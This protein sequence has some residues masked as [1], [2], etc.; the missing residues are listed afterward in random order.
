[1]MGKDYYQ[2]L[3]VQK[4]ATEDEI[5]KAFRKLALKWHPDRNPDNKKQAEEKFKAIAEAYEVLNDPKK[6][7][8][9]DKYGEEGLKAGFGP[10]GPPGGG[11]AQGGGFP[12]GFRYT[13][14]NAE[15]IF[16]QFFGGTNPFF[17]SRFNYGGMPSGMGG[18]AGADDMEEDEESPFAAYGRRSAGP[19]KA[20]PVKRYF[21][22]TLEE[23]YTGTTKKMKITKSLQDASGHEM[24]AE[25]ILTLDVKRGWKT[26]TKVTFREEGDE[27]PGIIPADIVFILQEKPHPRFKR[28]GDN[29][30]ITATVSLKEALTGANIEVQTLDN[31]RLRVKVE[32]IISPGYTKVVR[33]EGMP[34]QKSPDS[35][36]DLIINFDI[37]F[38]RSLSDQQKTQIR[39]AL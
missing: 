20:P 23:L 10:E 14:T 30:I 29:L 12:G 25:K 5:K 4:T 34:L 36:G 31:R 24:K 18:G 9:Y 35:K 26:G 7:A 6:K 3:G 28:D 15:D 32:E 16:A 39:N 27:K 22:C 1:V 8:V 17:S 37:Q 21:Q 2:I 38:P 13:P 19:R 11:F 33:G